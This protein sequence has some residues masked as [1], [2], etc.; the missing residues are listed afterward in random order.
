MHVF[1]S[2]QPRDSDL[3]L[4]TVSR[5]IAA[6][7]PEFGSMSITRLAAQ[8]SQNYTYRL[9][10]EMSI[11]LPRNQHFA[12]RLEREMQWLPLISRR[13]PLLVPTPIAS[14]GPSSE[15]PMPWAI[16]RWI[17]GEPLS[18]Q[19]HGDEVESALL[20]ASFIEALRNLDPTDAPASLQDRS[21]EDR[22]RTIRAARSKSNV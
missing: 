2:A 17:E 12:I 19:G 13:L 10:S 14:A 18:T 20:L 3:S 9:G 16:Y 5:L 1:Y 11:R 15:F 21:L 4:E 8:G 7:F 22:D 6:N